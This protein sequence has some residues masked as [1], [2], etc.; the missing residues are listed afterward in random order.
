MLTVVSL[1][2]SL[3]YP[4]KLD[5]LFLK[6]FCARIS[7]FVNKG[8]KF[9]IY[10]G[11]GYLARRYQKIFSFMKNKYLLDWIGIF[12]T[13]ENAKRLRPYLN[14]SVHNKI[15]INPTKKIDFNEHVLLAAGWKPGWST[16]Y[17]AILL[18]K[19]LGATQVINMTNVDHVYDKDPSN[20]ADAKPIK[21][22]S[23]SSF[24]G[25]VGSEWKPGLNMP[26][27][28][29]AAKEAERV[30][31]KVIII[32]RDLKNLEFLLE[33]KSFNGTVIK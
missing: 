4:R 13:R 23:W 3:I 1:G 20:H 18:A 14:V 26:F 27:D 25:L 32:G 15:I 16:D 17:D 33:E 10:C 21:E 9:A 30:G 8:E 22:I 6:N 12:A 28:P 11:G 7:E 19:N 24:R 31:L 2:G 5:R 29:I